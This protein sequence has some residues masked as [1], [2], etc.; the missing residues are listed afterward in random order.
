MNE[1][2]VILHGQEAFQY[3]DA[4]T[5][6]FTGHL[7]HQALVDLLGSSC[8]RESDLPLHLDLL[9][10]ARC[11]EAIYADR[12]RIAALASGAPSPIGSED[13][14][15]RIAAAEAAGAIK[16]GTEAFVHCEALP[17][18]PVCELERFG[19][20]ISA[21]LLAEGAPGT[22][23]VD[24]SVQARFLECSFSKTGLVKLLAEGKEPSPFI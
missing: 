8:L 12:A 11:L 1:P 6:R 20:G 18:G 16:R 21:E 2:D 5:D 17:K 24:F 3:A 13:L 9:K 15:A 4:I 23:P 22:P 14:R 19:L 10:Y 7:V